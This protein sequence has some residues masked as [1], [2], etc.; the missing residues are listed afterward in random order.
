[1]CV[2]GHVYVCDYLP[3]FALIEITGD[4]KLLCDVDDKNDHKGF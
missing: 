2:C 3:V 4:S 1:M